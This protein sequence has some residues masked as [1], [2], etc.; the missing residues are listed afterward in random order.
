MATAAHILKDIHR[1]KRHIKDLEG[2][3]EQGPRAH[4][5]INSR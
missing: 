2:K 4:K 1:L 5:R 3:L